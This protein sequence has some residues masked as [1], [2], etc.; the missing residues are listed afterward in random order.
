[1]KIKSTLLGLLALSGLLSAP[2]V[3][4]AQTVKQSPASSQRI[5]FSFIAPA[6]VDEM[7]RTSDLILIGQSEQSLEEATPQLTYAPDG[8]VMGVISLFKVKVHRVF[9]G[10][11]RLKTV[12]VAQS[13]G[14]RKNAK[15]ERYVDRVDAPV[16]PMKK[17][18]RYLLFLKKGNGISAYFPTGLYYGK[19]NLDG[20]DSEENT[21]QDETFRTI[22][23][24]V[25]QRFKED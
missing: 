11:P 9:K 21:I 20:K 12:T 4:P 10:N 6:D 16:Q 18:G 17:G 15:G 1:M 24:E 22:Q 19:H 7:V 2:T 14:I 23:K 25:R 5:A 13:I 8:L 3:S